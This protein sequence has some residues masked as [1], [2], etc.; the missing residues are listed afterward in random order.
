MVRPCLKLQGGQPVNDCEGH[1]LMVSKLIIQLE[2]GCIDV[3][4]DLE[5][6]VEGCTTQALH[7][8]RLPEYKCQG[9]SPYDKIRQ[10][11]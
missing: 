9:P 2:P 1:R 11:D 4:T 10:A 7:L 3:G 5:V 8:N 6:E